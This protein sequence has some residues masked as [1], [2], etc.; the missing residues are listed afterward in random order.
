MSVSIGQKVFAMKHWPKS[1]CNAIFTLSKDSKQ[2]KFMK[3]IAALSR[4]T[5]VNKHL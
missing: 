1:I 5:L 3:L 4:I 2:I